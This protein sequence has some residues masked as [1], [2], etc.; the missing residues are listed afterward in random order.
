MCQQVSV[1]SNMF[2]I[3]TFKGVRPACCVKYHRHPMQPKFLEDYVV[4]KIGVCKLKAIIFKTV[5]NR[6]VC[7]DP[8]KKWVKKGIKYLENSGTHVLEYKC[9]S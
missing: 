7:A 2:V 3:L 9:C 4:Q 5:K 6:I 1:S 8:N